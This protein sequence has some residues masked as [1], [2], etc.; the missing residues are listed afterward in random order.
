MTESRIFGS[1]RFFNFELEEPLRVAPNPRD[2][3]EE[4][5]E[6]I[7]FSSPTKAPA[8][9]KRMFVVSMVYCSLFPLAC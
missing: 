2:E 8:N 6:E 5:R 4:M 3:P 7:I 9:T 1:F